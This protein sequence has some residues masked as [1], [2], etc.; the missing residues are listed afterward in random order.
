ML[1]WISFFGIFISGLIFNTL[2]INGVFNSTQYR[3]LLILLLAVDFICLLS[4]FAFMPENVEVVWLY[5]LGLI[6]F[7]IAW[8][9]EFAMYLNAVGVK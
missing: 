7:L 9:I 6:F 1:F 2:L 4:S 8:V 5:S 3:W